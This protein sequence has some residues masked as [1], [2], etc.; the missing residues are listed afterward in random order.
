M[1]IVWKHKERS[2]E[3]KRTYK[4]LKKTYILKNLIVYGILR[5]LLGN[6]FKCIKIYDLLKNCLSFFHCCMRGFFA[7]FS[8]ALRNINEV[9]CFISIKKAGKSTQPSIVRNLA[10]NLLACYK[11]DSI[12]SVGISFIM[13]KFKIEKIYLQMWKVLHFNMEIW[14]TSNNLYPFAFIEVWMK[15]NSAASHNRFFF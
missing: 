8:F 10:E 9:I 13:A 7:G 2:K 15:R 12:N 5:S 11:L 1:F 3:K 14:I 4:S 6:N